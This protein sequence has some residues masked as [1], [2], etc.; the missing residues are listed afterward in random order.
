MVVFQGIMFAG[1]NNGRG[2]RAPAKSSCPEDG[3]LSEDRTEGL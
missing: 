1:Y 2:S 3:V